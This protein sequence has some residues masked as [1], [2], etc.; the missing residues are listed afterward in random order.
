MGMCPRVDGDVVGTCVDECVHDMDCGGTSKCCSNG[1]GHVCS[2]PIAGMET[3]TKRP[4]TFYS[5]KT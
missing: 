4:I 1:C 3:K 5:I 2:E